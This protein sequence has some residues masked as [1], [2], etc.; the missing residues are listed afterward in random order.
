MT[1]AFIRNHQEHESTMERASRWRSSLSRTLACRGP[2]G[3]RKGSVTSAAPAERNENSLSPF[4]NLP[5]EVRNTIYEYAFTCSTEEILQSLQYGPPT[6]DAS[7]LL[8]TCRQTYH[9]SCNL[10]RGAAITVFPSPGVKDQSGFSHSVLPRP[11]RQTGHKSGRFPGE[12][13]PNRT[14]IKRIALQTTLFRHP[15]NSLED[16]LHGAPLT[17]GL[18]APEEFYLQVCLCN[19]IHWLHDHPDFIM[20]FCIAIERLAMA[21]RTLRRIVIYY[22]G[23]EWPAWVQNSGEINFPDIV[24]NRHL[25]RGY[26]GANWNL[27]AVEKP[28]EGTCKKRCELS[29]NYFQAHPGQQ[30][31]E[32]PPILHHEITIDYYD[33]FSVSGESCVTKRP[34]REEG[35]E[36]ST[37]NGISQDSSCPTDVGPPTIRHKSACSRSKKKG[38]R[39]SGM[40]KD[41]NFFRPLIFRYDPDARK[42]WRGQN[43]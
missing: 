11:W 12:F 5:G 8:L 43:A 38:S 24:H 32:S 36:S 16:L 39:L 18:W 13:R 35:G 15:R 34:L 14:A 1:T 25:I 3:T 20:P 29:W 10:A 17:G 40:L 22:C 2:A 23:R 21:Y 33:S 41:V 6:N 7:G 26:S 30:Q 9:E 37:L 42:P 28:L 31:M 27:R 4:L 19:A